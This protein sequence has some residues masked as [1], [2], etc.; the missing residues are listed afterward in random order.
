MSHMRVFQVTTGT[1]DEGIHAMAARKTRLDAAVLD[2]ITASSD[3]RKAGA[4]AETLQARAREALPGRVADAHAR[5]CA[6]CMRL[7]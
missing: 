2:G 3:G 6:C 7:W 5:T 4:A 1:V